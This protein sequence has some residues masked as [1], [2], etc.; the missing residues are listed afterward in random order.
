MDDFNPADYRT[1]FRLDHAK[2]RVS[3]L[4][5]D[6]IMDGSL[7]HGKPI[8]TFNGKWWVFR[9]HKDGERILGE[10]GLEI[11]KDKHK[12]DSYAND[13]NKYIAWAKHNIVIKHSSVPEDITRTELAD[14]FRELKKFWHFYGITEF[15][16]H[17]FA[18]KKSKEEGASELL[19][20]N[21][22]HLEK[23]KFKG[24]D[25]LNSYILENGV[26]DNLLKFFSRKYFSNDTDAKYLYPDELLDLASGRNINMDS[27]SARKN[28]FVLAHDNGT[29]FR[30]EESTAQK[31]TLEFTR[32]EEAEFEKA[33]H[34]LAGTV[35][36]RGKVQG[37]VV[38]SP[39]LDIKAAMEVERKMEKGDILVV[40][41]T[42]PDLMALCRK[43]GAIVTDQGGMLSHAAII[44]RELK[45]PCIVGT[46]NGTK[47]FKTGDIVEVDAHI[48]LV[49]ILEK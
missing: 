26:L 37:K 31:I 8:I 13:F 45:I 49:K 28:S 29:A 21:L 24:R 30:I 4:L 34:G 35:A 44:S 39:M 20:K 18:V 22:D 23:L 42:N 11:F 14:L 43:A 36:F 16:Y 41:S 2:G 12:Y 1:L 5:S 17:D 10:R 7:K 32:F 40:Q 47:V 6:F 25:L 15:V 46:V 38:I 27:L 48:G 9:L 19:K 3:C 33:S